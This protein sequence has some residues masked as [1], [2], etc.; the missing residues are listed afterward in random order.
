VW[1]SFWRGLF[2]GFGGV[3]FCELGFSG[4]MWRSFGRGF[5]RG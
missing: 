5:G 1:G 4:V 2:V 3:G